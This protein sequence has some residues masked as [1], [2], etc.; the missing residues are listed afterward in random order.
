MTGQIAMDGALIK[1]RVE[2]TNTVA[3]RTRRNPDTPVLL[4]NYNCVS[5]DGVKVR[6]TN[7]INT[8]TPD[9]KTL[10]FFDSRQLAVNLPSPADNLTWQ[11]K[12]ARVPDSV[13]V[14]RSGQ[15]WNVLEEFFYGETE[16]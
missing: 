5:E 4:V 9:R 15:Y 1:M 14:R 3:I 16:Q 8:E 7:F 12:G 11:M 10:E 6:G 13:Y 2:S